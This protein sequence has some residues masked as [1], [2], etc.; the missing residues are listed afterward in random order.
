MSAANSR[1]VLG[2]WRIAQW[3]MSAQQVADLVSA[4]LDLGIDTFDTA[5]IYGDYQCESIFGAALKADPTLESRIK[6]IG[7]CGI[8]LVSSAR[9]AHRVKHYN[10]SREHI[11]SSVENSLSCLGV[12]KLNLLLIHRPDPLMHADEIAD[13]FD[14]LKRAGKVDGFG[15]SNFLPHQFE[16]L[17]SRLDEPLQT[18]QIEVSLMHPD[19]LFDGT[20][21]QCQRLNVTPQ[22]WSPLAGGALSR[23]GAET[24]LGRALSRIGDEMGIMREQLAIAWLL[25]HPARINPVL[26]TGKLHRIRELVEAQNIEL[27]RQLWFELLEAALGRE[28]A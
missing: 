13:A 8:A 5:D 25:R 21:D 10:T 12:E 22:A 17:Q 19:G 27:E 3:G 26:G 11:I 6:L 18:N 4:C 24:S 2:L 23:Q 1:F 14:R 7:K 9:P 20:L 28:V 16:L 15:V